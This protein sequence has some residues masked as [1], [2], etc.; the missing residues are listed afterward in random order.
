MT[1]FRL[2]FSISILV[3]LSIVLFA[4]ILTTLATVIKLWQGFSI[5]IICITGFGL[6][7]QMYYD[8][9]REI[10]NNE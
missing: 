2:V 4:T 10:N 3:L 6:A 8:A 5:T 9:S 1:M 7:S